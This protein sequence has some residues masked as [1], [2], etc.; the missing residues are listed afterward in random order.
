MTSAPANTMN[1]HS[2][3]CEGPDGSPNSLTAFRSGVFG[4][5]A[6][7]ARVISGAKIAARI[8]QDDEHRG[9]DRHAV[10]AEAAPEQG[11]G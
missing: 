2:A 5:G 11:T 3:L 9:G 4:P 7:T 8:E 1:G 6:P 10:C